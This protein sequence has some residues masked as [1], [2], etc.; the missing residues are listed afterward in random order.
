MSRTSTHSTTATWNWRGRQ[1]IAV[2]ASS[3][4]PANPTEG[5]LTMSS[6]VASA[7]ASSRPL[8][9]NTANTPTVTSAT[10][11][12][13]DS[14]AI[15][16]IIPGRCSVAST[17]RVPNRPANSAISSATYSAGSPKVPAGMIS[18]PST[19]RLSATA[20]YCSAR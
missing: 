6:R 14:S 4:W 20:L 11:L 17:W 9:Q 15:A 18:S 16:S 10:S 8:N 19:C 13:S 2:N 3:I 12:T 7:R 5:V 1:M